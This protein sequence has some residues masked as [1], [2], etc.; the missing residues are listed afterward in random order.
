MFV[1][2]FFSRLGFFFAYIAGGRR[3]VCLAIKPLNASDEKVSRLDVLWIE[4]LAVTFSIIRL[5]FIELTEIKE[6]SIQQNCPTPKGLTPISLQCDRSAHNERTDRTVE[7][8]T[9]ATPH[10]P[11]AA[12]A[13][14][15]H[16]I[17]CRS[18]RRRGFPSPRCP[19]PHL[20]RSID[21]SH[22]PYPSARHHPQ[23]LMRQAY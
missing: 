5:I 13:Q 4:Y 14:V 18:H 17:L 15:H 8:I 20:Y 9:C 7:R 22:Q 3:T 19:Q 16:S 23:P 12:P 6:S 11:A 1:L 10:A 2:G 21:P